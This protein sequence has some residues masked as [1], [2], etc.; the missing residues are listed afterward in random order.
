MEGLH[1]EDPAGESSLAGPAGLAFSSAA[2]LALVITG[3]DAEEGG[4]AAPTG[5]SEDDRAA[6]ALCSSGLAQLIRF[7][8]KECRAYPNEFIEVVASFSLFVGGVP[9]RDDAP[10][11]SPPRASALPGPPR[12]FLPLLL[13]ELNI[14]VGPSDTGAPCWALEL[15]LLPS[16]RRSSVAT[17]FFWKSGGG[18]MPY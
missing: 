4:D 11:S 18:I 16:R 17:V 3:D 6:R 10:E 1:Y 8:G 13:R 2:G 14:D 12:G 7:H 9:V 15:V 5:S